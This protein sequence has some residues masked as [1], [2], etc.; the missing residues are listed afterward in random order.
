MSTKLAG[1]LRASLATNLVALFASSCTAAGSSIL[2]LD[3][4]MDQQGLSSATVRVTVAARGETFNHTFNGVPAGDPSLLAV[5]FR[6]PA[7][8]Q[9]M[10]TFS[11]ERLL[12]TVAVAVGHDEA[13]VVPGAVVGPI[14]L[15]LY[16]VNGT[17]GQTGDASSNDATGPPP[18]P[19]QPESC[20]NGVDD[21]CDELIDCADA[22]CGPIARC[23]PG[24]DSAKL[25]ILGELVAADAACAGGEAGLDF[26]DIHQGFTEPTTCTGCSCDG[27]GAV[28]CQLQLDG[29]SNPQSCGNASLRM[30]RKRMTLGD[31]CFDP[32]SSFLYFGPIFAAAQTCNAAKGSGTPAAPTWTTSS[33]LCRFEQGGGC[34]TDQLCIPR[35][36]DGSSCYLTPDTNVDCATGYT[37]RGVWF[38]GHGGAPV[39]TCHCESP[40]GGSCANVKLHSWWTGVSQT[41]CMPGADVPVETL[42]FDQCYPPYTM[43]LQLKGE[44]SPP[45]CQLRTTITGQHTP[46]NPRQLCCLP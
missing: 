10:I 28:T 27:V 2:A 40:S 46:Q 4:E 30:S 33:R 21:D 31:P 13:Q 11:A 23:A 36:G 22:D 7:A 26:I 14:R 18:C 25:P 35:L 9:G 3:V 24:P 34:A 1:F 32:S 43:G 29:Y 8:V 42:P 12:A 20:F 45:T 39:C 38:T 16:A 19:G 17:D 15:V 44:P 5:G 6:L 37:S 41:S